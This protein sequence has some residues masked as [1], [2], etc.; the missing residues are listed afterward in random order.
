MRLAYLV[1]AVVLMVLALGSNGCEPNKPP[2]AVGIADPASGPAP[3]VVT[4][5]G[6]GSSDPNEDFLTCTWDFGDGQ[7]ATGLVVQHTYATPGNFIA[8]LTVD[9]GRGLT[10]QQQFSIV[11]TAS[12]SSNNP[13]VAA[14][15]AFPDSGPAPLTVSFDSAGSSD[16]DGDAISCTW[17]FGDGNAGRGPAVQHTYAAAGNFTATLTVA[18][19]RGG[20]FREDRTLWALL[21][22]GAIPVP[23]KED[24]STFTLPD[25]NFDQ[26]SSESMDIPELFQSYVT[27]ITAFIIQVELFDQPSGRKLSSDDS[28]FA[29]IQVGM[30][31]G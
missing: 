8:I 11:V 5:D 9:D 18:D 1:I 30:G 14:G 3:L 24:T 4:F 2:V 29:N 16:P 20:S 26:V 17:D 21:L 28:L 31:G 25:G 12:S 22:S 15:H 27:T 23:V 7:S 13:P 6:T 10:A 19:G